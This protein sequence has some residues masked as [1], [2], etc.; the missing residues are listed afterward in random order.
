MWTP[1]HIVD[2]RQ[3]G[4]DFPNLNID[5]VVPAPTTT[6]W[7]PNH[8]VDVEMHNDRE[9]IH[10]PGVGRS[11]RQRPRYSNLFRG[12][13]TSDTATEN[14]VNEDDD[15]LELNVPTK[16][17]LEDQ[18]EEEDT[19]AEEFEQEEKEAPVEEVDQIDAP[20][21]ELGDS[22]DDN[23]T[24]QPEQQ[25][26]QSML[27]GEGDQNVVLKDILDRINDLYHEVESNTKKL[28]ARSSVARVRNS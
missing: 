2:V 21:V 27:E 8:T 1:N 6:M 10:E 9:S 14:D 12:D 24:E 16:E 18:E 13:D 20:V 25:C 11:P 19:D 28:N 7:T 26:K 5:D 22:N 15:E 23:D 17:P 3:D 4:N